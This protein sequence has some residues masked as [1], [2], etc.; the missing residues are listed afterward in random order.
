MSA[1]VVAAGLLAPATASAAS[2]RVA[3]L[4]VALRAHAV[5]DG[6]IDGLEGPGTATSVPTASPVSA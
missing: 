3:A 4:Q 6:T 2:S 1:A 5:Y